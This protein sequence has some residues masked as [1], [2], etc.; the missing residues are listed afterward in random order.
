MESA[1]ST[2]E[3]EL[4]GAKSAD[5][6][7]TFKILFVGETWSGS[8]ARALREALGKRGDIELRSVDSDKNTPTP[9]TFSSK[10]R[11]RLFG[12]ALTSQLENAVL[13]AA[14]EFKPHCIIFYKI[15]QFS[16]K[17]LLGL[18]SDGHV[19]VNIFPDCSPFTHGANLSAALGLYDLV[20]SRKPFH[21]KIWKSEYGYENKCVFVPHGYDPTVHLRTE[22]PSEFLY[23]VAL[24]AS[25]RAEYY[26]LITALSERLRDRSIRLAIA[27]PHWQGQVATLPEG[28]EVLSQRHGNGY[29]DLI[30]QAKIVLAPVQRILMHKGKQYPGDEDSARTYEI[31]ASYSFMIHCH[32]DFIP[33]AYDSE[34]EVPT[35]KSVDDLAE[36]ISFYLDHEDLR[37]SMTK[38]AHE[39]AVPAYSVDQRAQDIVDHLKAAVSAARRP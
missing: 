39:R 7:P 34:T 16:P 22:P 27:G 15:P 28:W 20:I 10:I 37:Q 19:I 12:R 9:A 4:I 25:G 1:K 8:S 2:S 18:K 14:R 36:K 35:Y 23:D 11:N 31:T 38:A 30:R 32:T 29:I 17:L 13:D 21:P 5:Q 24:V 3:Q 26:E 33:Q 6:A